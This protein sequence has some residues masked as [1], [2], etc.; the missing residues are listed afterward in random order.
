MGTYDQNVNTNNTISANKY[1]RCEFP[2]QYFSVFYSMSEQTP[3]ENGDDA[4][5]FF[6][7][8]FGRDRRTTNFKGFTYGFG[9]ETKTVGCNVTKEQNGKNYSFT[10]TFTYQD[11]EVYRIRRSACGGD[12]ISR[13][14]CGDHKETLYAVLILCLAVRYNLAEYTLCD[15]EAKISLCWDTLETFRHTAAILEKMLYC[16]SGIS[17]PTLYFKEYLVSER[18]DLSLRDHLLKRGTNGAGKAV[19]NRRGWNCQI[20]AGVE[21]QLCTSNEIDGKLI[22]LNERIA[23]EILHKANR[24]PLLSN[25]LEIKPEN[26]DQVDNVIN[27]LK[28]LCRINVRYFE[29]GSRECISLDASSFA[30]VD[31]RIEPIIGSA[32]RQFNAA[33]D[34]FLAESIRSYT[35]QDVVLF[36]AYLAR[37]L[38]D[39]PDHSCD[40]EQLQKYCIAYS[41]ESE[42]DLQTV[43]EIRKDAE[44]FRFIIKRKDQRK[45]QHKE[46][47]LVFLGIYEGYQENERIEKDDSEPK[48]D[49]VGDAVRLLSMIQE[50]DPMNNQIPEHF[51]WKYDNSSIFGCVFLNT[52]TYQ[53]RKVFLEDLCRIAGDA[54]V[55]NRRIQEKAIALL[56]YYLVE[57]EQMTGKQREQI[58]RAAYGR[59]MY[60]IQE[61]LWEYLRDNYPFYKKTVFENLKLACRFDENRIYALQDPNYIFLGW[62]TNDKSDIHEEF[63]RECCI[64]QHRSW[65]GNPDKVWDYEEVFEKINNAAAKLE[66]AIAGKDSSDDILFYTYG[67][68]LLLLSLSNVT[69]RSSDAHY[70][71][72]NDVKDKIIKNCDILIKAAIL[73]DYLTR[74]YNRTY[75]TCD[76]KHWKTDLYLLS[77]GIR[78]LCV[79]HGILNKKEKFP[80]NNTVVCG[81]YRNWYEK[82]SGRWKVLMTRLLSY[83]DFFDKTEVKV[84]GKNEYVNGDF[85][86]YDHLPETH[87]EFINQ[88]FTMDSD[89]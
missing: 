19:I 34:P 2:Y 60:R 83:T 89:E 17:R 74:K 21:A 23:E 25:I 51:N 72:K 40:K 70:M 26:R 75:N 30:R 68:N 61:Y 15:S 56:S 86:E 63:L 31:V 24:F 37:K 4:V 8:V 43:K 38:S 67:M 78:F 41:N 36:L 5:A 39:V 20:D 80:I 52:L 84:L 16:K 50:T 62:D 88:C 28:Q 49:I 55:R 79:Y 13:I 76:P 22:K 18:V 12:I 33:Y 69:L 57:S 9:D 11:Q 71:M 64:I 58:F 44:A 85:L 81:D 66:T 1:Q 32:F 10:F 59:D 7:K 77:G 48:R 53:K 6:M 3:L 65:F 27:L 54:S 73:C 46:L 47:R 29:S 87:D 35:K 82:E 14:L 42:I 45:F